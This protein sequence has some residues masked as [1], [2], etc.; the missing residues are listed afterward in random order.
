[1][2]L[3]PGVNFEP[4]NELLEALKVAH[5]IFKE[6]N[7][8]FVIT[9]LKDREHAPNSLHYVG[10]AFDCRIRH[11]RDPHILEK[12]HSRLVTALSERYV[13]LLK[14]THIHIQTK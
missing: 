6:E 14:P 8:L 9:S 3:K 13:V 11:I 12:I 4:A 10:K 2:L 7:Q 5:E 1:M